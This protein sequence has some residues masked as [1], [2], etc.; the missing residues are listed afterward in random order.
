MCCPTVFRLFALSAVLAV[1]APAAAGDKKPIPMKVL[2][3]KVHG[4]NQAVILKTYDG[5][6][7]LPIWI[8]TREAQAIQMRLA[9]K[10][11]SRPLTHDLMESMIAILGARVVRVEVDAL[12]DGIF[13]GKL[14][15]R[16]V[17][18]K[19]YRL[20]GRPSD[21]ITLSLRA[22]VPVFVSPQVLKKAGIKVRKPPSKQGVKG[23]RRPTNL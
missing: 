18:G 9:G 2:G 3:I 23:G 7:L 12:R 4:G 5:K 1:A 19:R 10:K 8:G 13:I 6:T 21:L 15:L 16:D 11:P 14:N 17:Q 22:K 20:D